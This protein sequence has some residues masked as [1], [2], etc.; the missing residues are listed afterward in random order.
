MNKTKE[1]ILEEIIE[2]TLLK[3]KLVQDISYGFWDEKKSK[4]ITKQNQT[5]ENLLLELE[6]VIN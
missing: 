2:A 5:I 3:G 1:K 4:K 6:K